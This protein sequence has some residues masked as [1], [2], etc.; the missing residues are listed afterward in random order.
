MDFNIAMVWIPSSITFQMFIKSNSGSSIKV[1]SKNITAEK[2]E[3]IIA[4]AQHIQNI[5]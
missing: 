2:A 5:N 4:I 3:A 1:N